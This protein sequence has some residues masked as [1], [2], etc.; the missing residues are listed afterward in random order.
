LVDHEDNEDNEDGV[1][2]IVFDDD[3]KDPE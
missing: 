3:E 2:A 1:A